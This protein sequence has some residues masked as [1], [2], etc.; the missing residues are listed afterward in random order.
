[1]SCH[2]DSKSNMYVLA[3]CCFQKSKKTEIQPAVSPTVG[4]KTNN[5]G[6]SQ[7]RRGRDTKQIFREVSF[8]IRKTQNMLPAEKI[9]VHF[10]GSKRNRRN[11]FSTCGTISIVLNNLSII[12]LLF[13]CTVSPVC[14]HMCVCVCVCVCVRHIE[15][16]SNIKWEVRKALQE[17]MIP[18]LTSKPRL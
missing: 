8:L 14:L 6:H 1:M 16:P 5:N 17:E 13:L 10:R 12:P 15:E 3:N 4:W 2:R 18:W 7:R 11:W 9:K